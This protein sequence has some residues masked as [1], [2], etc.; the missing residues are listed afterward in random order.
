MYFVFGMIFL[1][2]GMIF[3]YIWDGLFDI[4]DGL[5]DGRNGG[6]GSGGLVGGC[7]FILYLE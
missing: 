6:H 4:W 1:I 5:F 2:F 7:E 3:F